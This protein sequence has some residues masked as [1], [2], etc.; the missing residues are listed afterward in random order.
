[1]TIEDIAIGFVPHLG[2]RG[3]GHLRELFGSARAVYEASEAELIA[4]AG[5]RADVAHSIARRVGFEEAQR[6]LLYCEQNGIRPLSATDEHYPE[7]LRIVSDAPHVLYTVGSVEALTSRHILSVVGTRKMTSYGE[8]MCQR[9][10]ERLAERYADLVVVSG[11]ALGVDA[12]A[13]RAAVECGVRTVGVIASPLPRVTPAQNSSL[14]REILA[15]GGAIVSELHSQTKQNGAYYIPRNRIIAALGEGL[16]LVESP[17]G[18]GSLSTVQA[19]D[20]YSRPVMALPA[21]ATDAMSAG[22]NHLI[23]TGLASLV[24]SGDDVADVLGWEAE[25]EAVE[26]VAVCVEGLSEDEQRVVACFEGAM[27]GLHLETI[28]ERSGLTTSAVSATLLNLELSGVVR[29]LPGKIY[30]VL[31]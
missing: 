24:M 9:I 2:V 18:G 8:H 3:I 16:L 4:R 10:I 28:V 27:D 25:M 7:A 1:M 17:V 6:E 23:K 5:L 20:G 15:H 26:R 31:Q 21:R 13:H 29:Q 11:L 12:A 30:E 19:A 22:S 14:G